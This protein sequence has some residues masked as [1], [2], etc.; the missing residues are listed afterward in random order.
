MRIGNDT[1]VSQIFVML[2]AESHR[3]QQ[4]ESASR[5]R[6]TLQLDRGLVAFGDPLGEDET[7]ARAGE[8]AVKRLGGAVK[9]LENSGLIFKRDA[10][11]CVRD[12]DLNGELSILCNCVEGE[13]DG[14]ARRGV[15]P[16]V[17]R[18]EC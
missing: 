14:P 3:Q 17:F 6:G 7:Q 10:D 11:A 15:A 18:A 4:R 2:H 12:A 9:A 5:A 16:C 8:V 1:V 13:G